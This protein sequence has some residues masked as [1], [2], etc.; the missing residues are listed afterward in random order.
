MK[1]GKHVPES[2]PMTV[3]HYI[4]YFGFEK[5]KEKKDSFLLDDHIRICQNLNRL[6]YLSF[7]FK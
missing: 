1:F 2:M 7:T 6:V 4:C 3:C 5:R